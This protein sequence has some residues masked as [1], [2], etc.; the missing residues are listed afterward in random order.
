[1]SS[2][3]SDVFRDLTTC[4]NASLTQVFVTPPTGE[5]LVELVWRESGSEK[6]FDSRNIR[7]LSK[8]QHAP[9]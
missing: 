2:I 7:D 1:M 4:N 3:L 6:V 5:I 8:S 9:D